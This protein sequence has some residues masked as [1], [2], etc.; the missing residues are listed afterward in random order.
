MIKGSALGPHQGGYLKKQEQEQH[1]T[2]DRRDRSDTHEAPTQPTT[3]YIR[4]CDRGTKDE[5]QACAVVAASASPSPS[6]V[7]AAP[8]ACDAGSSRAC[9]PRLADR[10]CEGELAASAALAGAI[11]GLRERHAERARSCCCGV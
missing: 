11:I 8:R 4:T 9:R 10:S 1:T 3:A 2:S 6:S 5:T 7:A